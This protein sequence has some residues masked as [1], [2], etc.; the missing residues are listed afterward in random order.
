LEHL[1]DGVDVCAAE[2]KV[3][4]GSRA[5]EVFRELDGLRRGMPV[6]AYIYPSRA[7]GPLHYEIRWTARYIGHVASVGGAHPD[8]MRYR[9]PSTAKHAVDNCGHWAVFWEVQDLHELPTADHIRVCDLCGFRKSGSYKRN[10]VPERP[11][12]IDHP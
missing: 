6:D 7:D 12:L 9:P 3:A 5:W 11:I 4:F 1:I 2:G 8:D 10:F